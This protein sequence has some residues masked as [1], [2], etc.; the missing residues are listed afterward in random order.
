M[1]PVQ[2]NFLGWSVAAW[3]SWWFLG[4]CKL[5][6]LWTTRG[7]LQMQE[8]QWQKHAKV[9]TLY[10][11]YTSHTSS[12]SRRGMSLV[13][14]CELRQLTAP[15]E[16]EWIVFCQVDSSRTRPSLS[17]RP[18]WGILPLSSS[19]PK[20][21]CCVQYLRPSS[22]HHRLLP[23]W[24][25]T[26]VKLGP[27]TPWAMVSCNA[28]APANSFHIQLPWDLPRA[29]STRKVK[30][31]RLLPH[32]SLTIRQCQL[33]HSHCKSILFHLIPGSDVNSTNMMKS[34]TSL[35]CGG[36]WWPSSELVAA[37]ILE[38]FLGHL[39]GS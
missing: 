24:W 11:S 27:I 13:T 18:F 3:W 9:L 4:P 36:I 30:S 2:G 22:S 26:L 21:L 35:E 19:W 23:M 8:L 32:P 15:A 37:T 16:V 33:V 25:R 34:I 31:I 20:E 1:A 7:Y 39:K 29:H 17:T 14:W 6:K 28:I 12:A 38:A 10:R 5:S